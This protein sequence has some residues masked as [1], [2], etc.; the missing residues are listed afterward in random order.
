MY[1]YPNEIG[2]YGEFGGKFVPE[3]L[4]RPLEE[5]ETAFKELKNDPVFHAEY[6]SYCLITP[7]DRP[8]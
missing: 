5:I 1:P 8:H 7:E 3:T 6:K 2:R 4:M